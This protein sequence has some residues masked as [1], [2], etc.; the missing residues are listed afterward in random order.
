[1]TR[2]NS[3][4]R[5]GFI[6]TVAMIV[7]V[8]AL[9][10]PVVALATG[11]ANKPQCGP[12][13]EF[14]PGFRT[15]LPDCRAYELV[16]PPY[17][18]SA[19]VFGPVAVSKN[20]EQ[21]LTFAGSAFA[22]AGNDWFQG[23]LNGNFDAYEL[24]RTTSGWEPTALT[25]PATR[26]P[27]SNMMAASPDL[28]TTLW[29]ATT[30]AAFGEPSVEEEIYV[31]SGSGV[32]S[33]VGPGVG[34]EVAGEE[35]GVTVEKELGFVGASR[36][37]NR[38][39]FK[40]EGHHK[41]PKSDLWPGDSTH[42]G[43]VSLYEY[44][45]DG[46]PSAEPALVGVK[47]EGPL[48]G[49][50]HLNE[51]AKLI[52]SCSTTLG[53]SSPFEGS[54]YNAISADGE[55]V[56]FTAG[57]CSGSPEVNELYAR[58]DGEHTVAISEPL[59]PAGA[60]SSGEPC[61]GA[62]RKEGVFEGAS[63]D[64]KRVFFLSE[65]PLLN[66]VPAEGVKLY[67]ARLE[68]GAVAELVDVSADPTSG[69]SPN[70]QGV[71]RVSEDGSHVYF[72]AKGVL[73]S[74]KNAE[75]N[76]P[77]E[78]ADNLYVYDAATGKTVFVGTLLSPIEEASVAA[79]E[80]K[81][82]ELVKERAHAK[83][84]AQTSV[85]QHE[86]ERGEISEEQDNQIEK[87]AGEEERLFIR[88]VTGELGPSG[89]LGIDGDVWSSTDDRPAQ[90]TTNGGFLLFLSSANLTGDDSK[91]VPKLFEYDA[92]REMLTRVSI[93]QG[94][95]FEHDGAVETFHD[96]PSIPAL[97][98]GQEERP[99]ATQAGVALSGDGSRVFFT[100]A[101]R[102]TPEA[103]AGDTNVYEYR[104]GNVYLISDGRDVA[105]QEDGVQ[106]A[107]ELFGVSP[108][109]EDVFFTSA[110]ALV[111]QD[112]ES[113]LVLYDAREEG[114]F[115]APVLAPGCMGETCRGASGVSPQ[116]GVPGS[117]SSASGGNLTPPA[118]APLVKPVAKSLT[119]AQ[120]LARAL[121]ACGKK[122]KKRRASCRA[123]AK[124]GYGPKAE[125]TNHDRRGK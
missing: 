51:G 60:C 11:D 80:G 124:K 24:T 105:T 114:G 97:S 94:G 54:V 99:T 38:L 106:P 4:G 52:S 109:S 6:A 81:E 31:R 10:A 91:Q 72:V 85:A 33:L 83:Y 119:R 77:E 122:P 32:F 67:E 45:Y 63:E 113:Q 104:E 96:A 111:P 50:P 39:L 18:A 40:I 43:G 110:D 73:T 66:G 36:G 115:P 19:L 44:S 98:F 70:V 42:E 101:G 107:V 95:S 93:G 68:A 47:N 13:T 30:N 121:K 46:A 8:A 64:G 37:L 56:F 21:V 53:A 16:T 125:K 108:S 23:S 75:E 49:S 79:A 41:G 112:A 89:T 34:P 71:V 3:G 92:A 65:Q 123:Q 9:T 88:N 120:K 84:M 26:F 118:P 48:H 20:G 12:E 69:Q 22:G 7:G 117:A 103:V 2:S 17:K 58:V 5:V 35:L 87:Q 25:P 100:S 82:Q 57:T 116:L 15:Y 14:S 28:A 78:G 1:M 62:A 59:L 61:F 29:G 76:E 86:F 102:L 27:Y 74:G 90:A 55:T